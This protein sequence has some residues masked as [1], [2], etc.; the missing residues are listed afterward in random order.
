MPGRQDQINRLFHTP[1]HKGRNQ[2]SPY[3]LEDA[4]E[5]EVG[6]SEKA[7]GNRGVPGEHPCGIFR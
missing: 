4:L 6:K 3:H 5:R 2:D 7:E 1:R